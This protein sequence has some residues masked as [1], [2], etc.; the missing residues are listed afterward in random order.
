VRS[1]DTLWEIARRYRVGVS[2]LRD[3]N[4]LRSTRIKP[5]QQLKIPAGV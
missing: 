4:S 2:E 1:G 5:G 3:W